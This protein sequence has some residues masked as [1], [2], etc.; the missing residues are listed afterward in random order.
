MN[1][2]IKYTVI[3]VS[4]IVAGLVLNYLAIWIYEQSILLDTS[5]PPHPWTV[6]VGSVYLSLIPLGLIFVVY[7]AFLMFRVHQV[8]VRTSKDGCG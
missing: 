1:K 4:F 3:G 6:M 8:E 5:D 7:S 2:A